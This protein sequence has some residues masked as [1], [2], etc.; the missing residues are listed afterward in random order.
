MLFVHILIQ[1]CHPLFIY[2]NFLRPYKVLNELFEKDIQTNNSFCLDTDEIDI[3][4]LTKYP[5]GMSLNVKQD[6][7]MNLS[8]KSFT[9]CIWNQKVSDKLSQVL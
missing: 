5:N 7:K 6:V 3:V 8:S 2:K 9:V 4:D 1:F